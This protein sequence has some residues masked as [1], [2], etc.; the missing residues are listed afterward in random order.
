MHEVIETLEN[1]NVPVGPIYSVADMFK[2]P[3]Y[4]A[5]E[6]FEEVLVDGK[7]LKLAAMAPKLSATPGKTEWAGPTRLGEHNEEVFI[8]TLGLS[9]SEL[10]QLKRD[11]II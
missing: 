10:E 8:K 6:L 11:K 9:R 5:R 2:D 7:P 1:V 3:Q 4:K